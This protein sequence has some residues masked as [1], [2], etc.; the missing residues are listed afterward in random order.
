M[1]YRAGR[2][3]P[4]AV[5]GGGTLSAEW[6][7]TCC[8]GSGPPPGQTPTTTT[9]THLDARR[10]RSRRAHQNVHRQ[11]RGPRTRRSELRRRG[12]DGLRTARAE[13]FGKDHGRPHPH[14]HPPARRRLGTRARTRRG[15]R[16]LGRARVDRAG[17]S[18]RGGRREPHR[19]REPRHGGSPQPPEAVRGRSAEHRAP[20]TVQALRRGRPHLEDVFGRHA[21][22][23]RPRGGAGRPPAGA[24][25]RRTHHRSRP[26]EP[27]R[28][29]GR[30]RD[31]WSVVAPPFC[32][33]PSTS[34]R[35]IVS[36]TPSRCS[37]TGR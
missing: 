4:C 34:K 22:A 20:R 15:R 28:P 21:P 30:D 33:P 32:S 1:P 6:R 7:R 24:L 14:H 27:Q 31:T 23:A 35:P 17:R 26:P 16:T 36:P 2:P 25:P 3:R 9:R 19:S 13:R 12:R 11:A 5:P 18:V 29:L 8:R 37:T 10:D